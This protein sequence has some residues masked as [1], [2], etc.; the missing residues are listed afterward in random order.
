MAA[1]LYAFL[2]LLF[3]LGLLIALSP[4]GWLA[5]VMPPETAKHAAD[6]LVKIGEAFVIAPI[7]VAVVDRAA[8]LQLLKEFGENIS[9]HIMGRFL[10]RELRDHLEPYLTAKFVRR[11]WEIDY[12]IEE[13]PN[14]AEF[15]KLTTLSQY[16]IENCTN[17]PAEY[18]FSYLVDDS[19]YPTIGKAEIV[20]TGMSTPATKD[21]FSDYRGADLKKK[22][23]SANGT[24]RFS[25]K[26]TIEPAVGNPGKYVFITESTE[27][28]HKGYKENF[29]AV[30][31]VL[32]T[33]LTI[34]YPE[35]K[36][37]VSVS[38]SFREN[39]AL[40]ETTIEGGRRWYINKPILPGQSFFATWKDKALA[41]PAGKK[42]AAS[43]AA[44]ATP[45]VPPPAAPGQKP[46]AEEKPVVEQ[47]PA[48][49]A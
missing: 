7:L 17:D 34:Y 24:S 29:S 4:W 2:V 27:C 31:P 39:G 35:D 47:K 6:I 43:T 10:P 45:P 40:E 33:I 30:Y 18:E 46:V 19:W 15:V 9:L 22:I 32:N 1:R 8:K 44:V 16:E 48:G 25:E 14:Q 36:L 28:F 21:K 23:K 20:R 38:L 5:T 12:R 37:D 3:V 49:Q 41:P 42:A 26:V 13:W 11:N